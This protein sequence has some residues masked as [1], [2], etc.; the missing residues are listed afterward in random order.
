M[1]LVSK[2]AVHLGQTQPISNPGTAASKGGMS[3]IAELRAALL[4]LLPLLEAAQ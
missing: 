4:N 2:D 1:K 3:S